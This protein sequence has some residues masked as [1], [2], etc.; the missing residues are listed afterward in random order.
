MNIL[1]IDDESK[2]R[3][4]LTTIIKEYA[5]SITNI[6]EAGNLLDGINV[7]KNENIQIVF[8][9]IEMPN[10]SGLQ[11]FDFINIEEVHFEI[12][13]TTAYSE[14]AIQAFEFSAIDYL[15]KPLRPN[16]VINS[17][18]KA[19]KA[20]EQNQVQQRLLELKKSLT[21][22]KFNKLAL[23]VEDGVLF[24][25]LEDIFLLE[26]DAMY[27]HFHLKNNKK[28]LISKPLKY[29]TDLLENKDMFYKPHRS[30]LVNLQ[31]LQKLVK[32]EG[33]YI[34]LENKFLV[35]VS[36]DKKDEL[37]KIISELN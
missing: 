15:L 3:S 23:P 33:T 24:I 1:I 21:S 32:K 37:N 28:L 6:F 31:Y 13:F 36:K 7:L 34:E 2:A 25:K 26:A 12:I 5:S 20:L 9:D 29:F 14:Y 10:H 8:L 18:D 22:D 4:L 19:K 17:I 16:K 11:L 35:P 30:F 27:T